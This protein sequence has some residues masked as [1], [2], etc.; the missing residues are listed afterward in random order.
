MN[1]EYTRCA[2]WRTK[3]KKGTTGDMSP[4]KRIFVVD[5]G[6]N[7]EV[8]SLQIDFRARAA[9]KLNLD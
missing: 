6:A 9:N 5:Y 8:S 1:S 2:G 7:Y 4:K 3:R